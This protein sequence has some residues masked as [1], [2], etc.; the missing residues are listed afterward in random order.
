MIIPELEGTGIAEERISGI[1]GF[2]GTLTTERI[3]Q[4]LSDVATLSP[5]KRTI[6]WHG[7]ST[8]LVLGTMPD[9]SQG[10]GI[11]NDGF[12]WDYEE[13]PSSG[14]L[15]IVG[16]KGDIVIAENGTII[17]CNVDPRTSEGRQI[18]RRPINVHAILPDGSVEERHETQTT[19]SQAQEIIRTGIAP[20]PE[21][22]DGYPS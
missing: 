19:I 10:I 14:A 1:A 18:S 8:V 9:G 13:D 16:R 2:L 17:I 12:R 4:E 21:S 22:W 7:S 6:T 20:Y 5:D 3:A 11:I 15:K